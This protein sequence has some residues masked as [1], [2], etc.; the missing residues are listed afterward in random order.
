[1]A[2]ENFVYLSYPEAVALHIELMRYLGEIRYGVSDRTLIESALARPAQAAAYADADL[3]A[4]AAT[5]LY[6]LIKN[7][8][9]VGGNK[10]TATFLVDSFLNRNG[11]FISAPP[12]E[13]IELVLAVEADRWQLAEIDAW[14]RRHTKTLP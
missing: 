8:P 1:M 7:H 11:W 13:F 9:W 3:I 6:G 4:Q 14:L 10:R 5:L 2:T 12:S